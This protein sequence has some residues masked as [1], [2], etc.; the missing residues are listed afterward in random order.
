MQ[1]KNNLLCCAQE[2]IPT[3]N[4]KN[5]KKTF[6]QTDLFKANKNLNYVPPTYKK[7]QYYRQV[8]ASLKLGFLN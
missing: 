4:L 1:F 7:L 6:T 2:I 5:K 3:K 8:V